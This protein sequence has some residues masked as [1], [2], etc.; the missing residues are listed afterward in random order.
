M[1]RTVAICRSVDL[2]PRS[3]KAQEPHSFY[4]ATLWAGAVGELRANSIRNVS[5][6]SKLIRTV[7]VGWDFD[8]V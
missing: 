4:K 3:L 2:S 5:S 8:I 1:E 7:S 6:G